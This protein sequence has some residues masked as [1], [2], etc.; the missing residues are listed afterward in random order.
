MLASAF[1]AYPLKG[2]PSMLSLMLGF[3]AWKP[4]KTPFH[5]SSHHGAAPT[6]WA[7]LRV[8]GPAAGAVVDAGRGAW[9]GAAVGAGACVGAGAGTVVGAG[10]AGAAVA[11]AG[12]GVDTGAA[13]P[14]SIAV[15]VPS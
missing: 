11:G 6:T 7:S 15:K 13:Q 14:A 1:S 5:I 2:V 10:A 12:V 8:T 4:S 9:V 3:L